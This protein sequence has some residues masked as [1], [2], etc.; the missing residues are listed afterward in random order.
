MDPLIK[1]QLLYQLSYAPAFATTA[2]LPDT[3]ARAVVCWLSTITPRFASIRAAAPYWARRLQCC[4]N[5]VKQQIRD[6][7]A[8]INAMAKAKD[9]R[10][11]SASPW[12]RV[13]REK[14]R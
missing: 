12:R 6:A 5:A 1:S 13:Y 4:D 9:A 14:E 10:R 8:G 7:R 2:E 3:L 11:E